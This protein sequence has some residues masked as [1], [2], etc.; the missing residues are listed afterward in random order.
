MRKQL[1]SILLA[2]TV[3]GMPVLVGCEREVSHEESTKTSS[4][5][6]Q[7]KKETTVTQEG[8]GTVVKE[9]SKTVD[10]APAH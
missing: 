1:A 8:D 2:A 9:K 10:N 5:G 3:A 6:T 7:V 4:D